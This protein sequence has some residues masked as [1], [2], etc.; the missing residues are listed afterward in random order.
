MNRWRLL[1][2]GFTLGALCACVAQPGLTTS[3][4][5]K[6]PSIRAESLFCAGISSTDL[7][8][9]RYITDLPT[10]RYPVETIYRKGAV[11]PKEE[12]LTC[13]TALA[14]WMKMT[15]QGRWRV[16]VAGEPGY[17]F[18]PLELAGK[19]QELLQRF[20]ARKWLD[21]KDWEWQTV[22]GQRE[23]LKFKSLP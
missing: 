2:A 7:L 5:A 12:G 3:P 17:G 8:T 22:A 6:K 4:V 21:L 10:V 1:F 9:V 23:Q 16:T 13:L 11:L 18:D 14:D 19:R 15:S 20:F